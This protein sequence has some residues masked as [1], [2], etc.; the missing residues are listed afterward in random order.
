MPKLV[1]L[2]AGLTDRSFEVTPSKAIVG[3]LDDN[4]LP[5]PEASVSSRHCEIFA[6]GDDIIV[7]D[8]GS[9]NGSFINEKAIESGKEA[10]LR[11]GQVLRLGQ[12]ELRYETGKRQTDQPRATVKI[13]DGGQTA[14]IA[15]GSVFGKKDNRGLMI[16]IGLGVILVLAIAIFLFIAFTGVKG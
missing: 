4:Q 2:T 6:K 1:V 12:V 5:L 13:S 16:F 10:T 8:L 9:T 3:R 15:A 7:K 14:V 11:P